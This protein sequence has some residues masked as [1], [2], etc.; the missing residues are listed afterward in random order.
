MWGLGNEV[1]HGIADVKSHR[2]QA[3]ATFLVQAADRLHQLDP[4][5]PVVY[6]G[7]AM[8]AAGR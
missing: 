8:K 2:A 3:F 4:Q 7:D 5:H 1:L 6:R